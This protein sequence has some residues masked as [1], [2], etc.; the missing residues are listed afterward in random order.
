MRVIVLF[1]VLNLATPT[2][3]QNS[4]AVAR[5]AFGGIQPV[6][7]PDGRTIA[8]SFHGS[9]ARMPAEGGTL[10]RLTHE[11]GW[12]IEPAWS[13]DGKHLAYINSPGL[14]TGPLRMISASEGTLVPLPKSVLA[15]GR[16]QFH[17]DGR[18]LL[19]MF[20][21]SGQPDRLQWYD[22]ATGELTPVNITPLEALHRG[23]M[24][25][26]QSPDGETI[27]FTKNF[28][29]PDEQGGNNGPATELWRV[30]S[31]GGTPQL[32]TR[33][34]ARIYGL[35]WSV[36]G[37]GVFVVTD[38]G[39]SLN[40]LWHLPLDGSLAGARRTTFGHTDEDWPSMSANGRWLVHT[41]NAEGATALARIELS[42][43]RRE[44]LS[45]DRLDFREPT[46]KARLEILDSRT[47]EPLTAR[48]SV[49]KVG[50]KFFFPLGALYRLTYG[51]GH[52]YARHHAEFDLPAG[53]YTVRVWHGPEYL[54]HQEEFE[55]TAGQPCEL[56]P[57]LVRWIDM[58]ARGWFSGENH[59]HANYGVGAWHSDPSSVRDQCEGEDLHVGNIVVANSDGD[60]VFDREFFLG[61]PD[62]LSTRRTILYWN[63]EFRSTIWGHLTLG[64]LS[65][66]V[67]PIFT[68]FKDTTNPWDVPTNA[69]IADRTRAQGGVVSYT[70]PT[71]NSGDPY[72]S[73]A[74]SGKGL[75]VDA[76]LGRVDTVDVMG[77]GYT[78]S[79][80]LWYSL[81]NCGFR[82]PAAAGT[83]VFLNR[84]QSMPPGW[85]RAYVKLTNGLSYTDWMRG[86]RAG[87]SFVTSGPML[88][89][90]ANDHLPGDTIKLDRP[91]K[92][93]LKAHASSK[94][95]LGLMEIIIDGRV[96]E[97]V[98]PGTDTR[99]ITFNGELQMDRTGWLAVRCTPPNS[100]MGAH[101]NPIYVEIPNRPR[102]GRADAK[103]LLK[104]IDRLESDLRKRDR[105]PGPG[106]DHALRQLG[107]ARDVYRRLQ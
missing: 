46:A 9:I 37:K 12:D 42:T 25:W 19:G 63:E 107:A 23:R 44:S 10:T 51:A 84:I 92:L 70:H 31:V 90:T 80:P 1:L 13:P 66:L 54:D 82:I 95:P 55:I 56:K 59:I 35:C 97:T 33:W 91:G 106:L 24:K 8:L 79:L 11:A 93:R 7:S 39:G 89:M 65:R 14:A 75:P 41:E 105:L 38:R 72:G 60:G 98:M 94:S 47:G 18:R 52:F 32:V 58:P 87:R 68:G 73:S 34:S 16:L 81:L 61:Q 71:S 21:M 48:V 100:S 6:I 4:N 67:E 78:G 69:D 53:R 62:P 77:G 22:L 76:A 15:R 2:S 45:I 28:D 30:P 3:A 49:M 74:Y 27:L 43:G 102:D 20:A 96:V 101:M 99:E 50:G 86:Q 64:S 36:D 88:D 85:G 57:R 40:D 103:L 5:R 26:A 83:D 104:W 17:P 29:L